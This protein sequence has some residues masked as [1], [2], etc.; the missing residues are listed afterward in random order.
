[1][2]KKNILFVFLLIAVM[3]VFSG[4]IGAPKKANDISGIDGGVFK[5]VN[6]GQIWAQ[7]NLIPTNTGKPR[8]LASANY[9]VL[10][11]D[12]NDHNAVYYGAVGN[13]LFYTYDA[14][15]NWHKATGLG[16]ITVRGIDIDSLDKCNIFAAGGNKVFRT[17]DCSRTWKQVYVDNHSSALV[18]AVL[19]DHFNGSNIF[20]TV[21]RGDLIKS[22]DQ[23][24]SWQTIYRFK[25]RITKL[26]MDPVDSRV[27]YA[28]IDGSDIYKSIDSGISWKRFDEALKEFKLESIVR[29]ILL[30]KENPKLIFIAT[31]KGILRSDDSGITW[32]QIEL[33][34]PEKK[35]AVESVA[36]NPLN[37][38]EIYYISGNTFY[39]SID[40]GE[41]WTPSKITTTRTG[42]KLII[43]PVDPR[44]IYLGVWRQVK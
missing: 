15:N 9:S 6:K 28:I 42:K 16:N 8:T 3:L 10:E 19:V 1:M 12:P 25:K 38:Q 2:R 20:I 37:A 7:K 21:M 44:I 18:D 24:E 4:C 35:A 29:E 40:G 22:S 34:P 31:Q 32:S 30:F 26:E 13:G 33:I 23:G 11:I 5:T 36:V 17:T 43:D 41:N 27:M 14:G 39:R